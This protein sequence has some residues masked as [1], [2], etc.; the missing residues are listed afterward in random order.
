MV[1]ISD[2]DKETMRHNYELQK[3]YFAD[4]AR[5]EGEEL[6]RKLASK[7]KRGFLKKIFGWFGRR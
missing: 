3:K 7:A 2:K 6:A 5:R 1:D 4:L